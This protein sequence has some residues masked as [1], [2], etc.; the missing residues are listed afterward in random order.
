MKTPKSRVPILAPKIKPPNWRFGHGCNP[1]MGF[2]QDPNPLPPIGNYL[3]FGILIQ[4]QG[5]T[6]KTP[7]YHHIT[8]TI[9]ETTNIIFISDFNQSNSSKRIFPRHLDQDIHSPLAEKCC[10]RNVRSR[11]GHP[12]DPKNCSTSPPS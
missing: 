9:R 7:F 4:Y 5:L 2:V 3:I 8:L 11:V 1:I 10:V 12:L 6:S